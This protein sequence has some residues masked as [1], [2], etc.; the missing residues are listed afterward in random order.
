M[1]GRYAWAASGRRGRGG[2]AADR[3]AWSLSQ[4]EPAPPGGGGAAGGGGGGGG[5]A[6]AWAPPAGNDA[7]WQPLG[8]ISSLRG[9]VD[10]DVRVAGRIN[11]VAVSPDGLRAYAV[12]GLGGLW[13]SGD[14]G[15]TWEPVG[16][17]RTSDRTTLSASSHTLSGGALHV[18]FGA[19]IAD[20]E[21]WLGTGEPVPPGSRDSGVVGSY[22][23]VGI[24]H[25][26]GPVTA[27]RADPFA[28]PWDP[29]QAVPRPAAGGNPAYA[30]LRGQGVFRFARDPAAGN[31]RTLLAATTAG[32]HRHDPAVA[33]GTDPWALVQVAAWE[34][35]AAGTSATAFVTDVAWL[36]ATGAHGDRVWACVVGA[37]PGLSGLW[38]STGGGALTP[39]PL[40]GLPATTQRLTIAA[41]PNHPDVLYVLGAGP[42][43]WRV[44][45]AAAPP[46]AVAV[47]NL[48][49]QIFGVPPTDLSWWVCSAAID[50]ANSSRVIIGGA[51]VNSPLDGTGG[52]A[53]GAFAAA[54]YQLTI[55]PAGAPGNFASNYVAGESLDPTWVGSEVHPDVHAITWLLAGGA[56]HVWVGCDGGV[57]RS[58]A[59][60]ALGSFHAR[61]SGM[62]VA[63]P[64]FVAGSPVSPGPVLAGMQDN[65]PQLRIGEGV[66]RQV[67]PMGDG[68]GVAF[69]PGDPGRF[70]VQGVRSA[71]EDD[72]R[73]RIDPTLRLNWAPGSHYALEDGQARFYANAAVVRPAGAGARTRLAIATD[74]VWLSERWG[75][76]HWDG[77]F[78]RRAWV[79]LATNTDPRAG[80][81]STPA[82]LNTDRLPPGPNPWG[83]PNA[84]PG[85]RALRWQ[86]PQRLLAVTRGSVHALTD[87]GAPGAWG[88]AIVATRE[89]VPVGGVPAAPAAPAAV[90]G[91][92]GFGEYNDLGVHDPAV[93]SFYLATSHP[94]DPLWW[95]DGVGRCHPTGLGTLPAGTRSPAYAVVVDTI[96]PTLVYVGTTAGVWQGR[97]T[98]PAAAG[99]A[100]TWAWR[101]F[102]NGLPEA[103]AQDLSIGVWPRPGG[104]APL[105]LL[106]AALQA[107]G[108]FEVALDAPATEHTYL[109]VHPFDTRRLLPTPTGDPMTVGTN[110]RR[111]WGLD[112]AYER[113]RD[114]RTGGGAPRA[115]PDGT[116]VTDFLWHASPDIVCRPAQIVPP[117]VIPPPP[118]LPWTSL[119]ADRFWL[120]SL[121]TAIRALPPAAFPD[122]P[123]IVADGRWTAWWVQRLRRIRVA[124]GLANVAQ[125]RQVRVDAALWNDARVQ[126]GFWAPPWA[127]AEPTEADLIERVV[128]IATPRA[129]S[130][131][132]AAV[133]S[134]SVA[135]LRRRYA[136]EVCVHHRGLAPAGGGDVAVTLLRTTLPGSAAAWAAVAPPPPTGLPAAL[137]GLPVDT[138]AGPAPNA[139]AGWAP[140]APWAFADAARP[141]RRPRHVT[142]A[143]QASVVTFDA[144]FGADAANTDVVLLALVHRRTEPVT[145]AAG[146]LRDA[147]LGSSHAAARSVR[148]VGV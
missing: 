24:L 104:G 7:L 17:W 11:D 140:P 8:P 25:R 146:G 100:P 60:G 74:R 38:Q 84:V 126:V 15:A 29:P 131:N 10:S 12:S 83:N 79:T 69:D 133:R 132:R 16:A 111:T 89:P 137:D 91:L 99:A 77:A 54:L 5:G 106:R 62:S 93:G 121:Q 114:H 49:A 147:V 136:V 40:P 42:T 120:W 26:T 34:A 128:G 47:A 148:V 70:V 22:G 97:F 46:A 63:E 75:A 33:P 31:P 61:T 80:D 32:L 98:P 117:A 118:T 81:A 124:L 109:R 76:S 37:L 39:V 92:P 56:S 86:T 102:A 101:Q 96:D 107:R 142:T 41:H 30:G 90:A 19:G 115:H 57:F 143:A 4:V 94:L 21:V 13:Y 45:G 66:W 65:G 9:S 144:D 55:A 2:R 20:D 130:V 53:N 108:I 122:A 85:I 88:A 14:A 105:R 113:N 59:G 116:P 6:G 72:R 112:W 119:P 23:G 1:S 138:E 125:P 48:P 141:A 51:A 123:L 95:W 110:R 64:G 134:A 67:S 139:L 71:W 52:A 103:A 68:G 73:T 87:P 50:P 58:A 82:A 28:D 135:V 27:A 35:L 3:T 18:R 129:T 78:W 145:L 36:P 44:D 43:L 127:A